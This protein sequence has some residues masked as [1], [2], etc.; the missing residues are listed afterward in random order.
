MR[1]S[2][3]SDD[4]ILHLLD[5]A[6]RGVPIDEISRAAKVSLR[7]FYRW[8]RRF[9]GLTAPAVEQLKQLEKENSH[10]R[11][12]VRELSAPVNAKPPIGS[13]VQTVRNPSYVGANGKAGA[14]SAQL[15]NRSTATLAGRF[16]ASRVLF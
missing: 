11:A 9:G 7:T 2:K 1:R 13:T 15:S 16:A 4:E 14:S 8:R 5:E 3:F 10:L 12:L 6:G